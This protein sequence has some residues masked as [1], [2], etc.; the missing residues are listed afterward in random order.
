MFSLHDKNYARGKRPACFMYL[1]NWN[2]EA[3]SEYILNDQETVTLFI[4]CGLPP[5]KMK[6]NGT[7][8]ICAGILDSLRGYSVF[9]R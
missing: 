1:S 3:S 5:S 8:W 4:K 9:T 7:I 2:R 6:N